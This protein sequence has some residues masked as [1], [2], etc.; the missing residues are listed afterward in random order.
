MRATAVCGDS[1]QI[2][3]PHGLHEPDNVKH[4][5]RSAFASN[6]R[7][8]LAPQPAGN[9]SQSIQNQ[10]GVDILAGRIRS[11]RHGE[12]RG[13]GSRIDRSDLQVVITNARN[14]DYSIVTVNCVSSTTNR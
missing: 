14:A 5:S 4:Q 7:G 6:G 3:M 12:L 10:R 11:Q 13:I 8:H 1:H 2:R 9:Q